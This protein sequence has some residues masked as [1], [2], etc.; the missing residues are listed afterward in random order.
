MQRTSA[1]SLPSRVSAI[2]LLALSLVSVGCAADAKDEESAL[3]GDTSEQA[4]VTQLTRASCEVAGGTT[5]TLSQ[6][7]SWRD[8]STYRVSDVVMGGVSKPGTFSIYD[9]PLGKNMKFR[10]WNGYPL[11][12]S[13]LVTE[14]RISTDWRR[15]QPGIGGRMKCVAELG[16]NPSE[17][18][19]FRL[20][21]EFEVTDAFAARRDPR[22]L[23]KVE[24]STPTASLSTVLQRRARD[25]GR[26]F[27]TWQFEG[28]TLY[29][30]QSST[31]E[32]GPVASL[33]QTFY[34]PDGTIF[35]SLERGG[36]YNISREVLTPEE[37]QV[38]PQRTVTWFTRN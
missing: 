14:T 35:A 33:L 18:D 32:G 1:K 15:D 12:Y 29:M 36:N 27:S 26:A 38:I 7:G 16:P 34:R 24:A 37:W 2:S 31:W 23:K 10:V 25:Y 8:T 5:F 21:Y 20:A 6:T 9:S 30:M 28:Q 22:I 11:L 4:L 17:Y 3:S 13:A 19:R